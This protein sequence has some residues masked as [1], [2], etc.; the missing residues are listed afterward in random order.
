MIT[1]DGSTKEKIANLMDEN[2]VRYELTGR[3]SKWGITGKQFAIYVGIAVGFIVIVV[4]VIMVTMNKLNKSS[5]KY[6]RYSDEPED[7]H[8]DEEAM[9]LQIMKEMLEEKKA[10][11]KDSG[12]ENK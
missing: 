9:R 5:A 8:I 10:K 12:K 11:G 2:G 3:T 7:E 6:S 4:T 1:L